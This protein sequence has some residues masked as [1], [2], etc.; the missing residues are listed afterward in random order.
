M[1]ERMASETSEL[2]RDQGDGSGI[3][4]QSALVDDPKCPVKQRL[5]MRIPLHQKK[6]H[7]ATEQGEATSLSP[8]IRIAALQEDMGVSCNERCRNT[9]G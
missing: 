7:T 4:Q 3:W 6:L 2:I 8:G 5:P 1:L 9:D